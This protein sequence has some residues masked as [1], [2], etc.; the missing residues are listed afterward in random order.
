VCS[1]DL[2]GVGELREAIDSHV[3]FLRQSP[4]GDLQKRAKLRGLLFA[5]LKEEVWEKLLG[6]WGEDGRLA[7]LAKGFEDGE[8]DLCASVKGVMETLFEGKKADS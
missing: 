3:V 5:L 7:G 1:S 4:D 2:E 8:A 6:G